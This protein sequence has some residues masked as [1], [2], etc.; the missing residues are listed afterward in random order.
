MILLTKRVPE[1]SNSCFMVAVE[2]STLQINLLF[3]KGESAFETN[4]GNRA[5]TDNWRTSTKQ[6]SIED[7][8]ISSLELTAPQS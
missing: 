3:L 6:N 7:L 5:L 2:V 8:K 1:N 4:L